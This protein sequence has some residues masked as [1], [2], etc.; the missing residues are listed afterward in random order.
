MTDEWEFRHRSEERLFADWMADGAALLEEEFREG[1]WRLAE[2]IVVAMRC[3][4]G[5]DPPGE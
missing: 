2:E 3:E 4:P 5:P 1:Y